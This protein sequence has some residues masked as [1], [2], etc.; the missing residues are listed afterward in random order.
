MF[1][2]GKGIHPEDWAKGSGFELG[3]SDQGTICL[4]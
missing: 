2:Q 4:L 1:T 3:A